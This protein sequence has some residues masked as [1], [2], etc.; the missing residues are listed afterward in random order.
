MK[1]MQTGPVT[2][3]KQRVARLTVGL[4]LAAM[5]AFGA[6]MPTLAAEG[7]TGFTVTGSSLALVSVTESTG[8]AVTLS[9]L[10]QTSNFNV[11]LTINDPSGTGAGWKVTATSTTFEIATGPNAGKKL[12]AGASTVQTP[13]SVACFAGSSCTAAEPTVTFGSLVIP[14]GEAG[15][16]PTA[17]TVYN[18]DAET[19]LGKM[20]ATLPVQVSLLAG[21]TF[22]GTYNSTLTLALVS[23]P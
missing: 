22:A 6:A 1:T 14:S 9:G 19:G 2:T 16:P 17:A 13:T 10:D 12:A 8:A 4:G 23:A 21:T 7:D 11:G 3:L 5:M 15:S 20:S 18:A